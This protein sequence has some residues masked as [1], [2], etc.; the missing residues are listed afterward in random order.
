MKCKDQN[1]KCKMNE[2]IAA[3]RDSAILILDI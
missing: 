3:Y 2:V 1:V